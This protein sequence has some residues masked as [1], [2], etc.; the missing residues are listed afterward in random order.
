MSREELKKI[1]FKQR[2]YDREEALFSSEAVL[3]AMVVAYNRA[4]EDCE[5]KSYLCY[6][7][8]DYWVRIVEVKEIDKL[9]IYE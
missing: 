5:A 3:D 2:N 4:L 8:D 1:P 9:R 7:E 6:D